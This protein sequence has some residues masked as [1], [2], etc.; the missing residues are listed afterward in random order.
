MLID[1]D[2]VNIQFIKVNRLIY[3]MLIR[4]A[5][6]VWLQCDSILC[7]FT[8]TFNLLVIV[9][10]IMFIINLGCFQ[11]PLFSIFSSKVI[12]IDIMRF[13]GHNKKIIVIFRL[14]I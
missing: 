1:F 14:V 3:L 2:A 10:I 7:E 11:W 4:W 13:I 6:C 5:V 8:A 12:N 9:I